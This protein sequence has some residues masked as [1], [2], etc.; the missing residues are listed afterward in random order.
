MFVDGLTGAA[1]RRCLDERLAVEWRRAGHGG[2][3][4]ARLMFDVD[5]F[6]RHN[7]RYGHQASDERLR[8][9]AAAVEAAAQR[10]GDLVARY[11]GEE[12]AGLLPATELDGAL[13]VAAGVEQRVRALGIEH[14][15]SDAAG[16]V[17][18]SVGVTAGVPAGAGEPAALVA[19]ADAQL[20]CAKREGRGRVCGAM[21]TA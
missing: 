7:D 17:S 20:Y 10:P 5:H 12:F 13:A 15:A 8:G 3:P 9:V 2:S 4:L 16:A 6:K 11:C 1:N 14:A 19:L 21:L 18:V